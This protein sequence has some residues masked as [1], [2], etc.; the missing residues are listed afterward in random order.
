MIEDGTLRSRIVPALLG[1]VFDTEQSA[2]AFA[3]ATAKQRIDEQS[4][5]LDERTPTVSIVIPTFNRSGLLV[6]ALESVLGQT[7]KDYE[8]IV[9]DDGS[10]DDTVERLA[11]YMDRIRY[12]YQLNRGVSAALNKGIGV[13]RGKW[14]SVLASDDVWLPTKLENQLKALAEL[15]SEFG[16][17]FTDCSYSGDP[18][19]GLSAFEQAGLA[20]PLGP[21]P[22]N[23]PMK[24]V[25]AEHLVI[26]VQSL[27]V[28]SSLLRELNGF[29]EA[30]M[31][32]EDTDLLFRLTFKTRFCFVSAPLVRIDRTP[33][34]QRLTDLYADTSDRS[35]ACQEYKYR[36]W[37]DLRQFEDPVS[38]TSVRGSLRSVYYDWIIAKLYALKLPDAL[39]KIRSLR[40]MDHSYRTIILTLSFR[41]GRKLYTTLNAFWWKRATEN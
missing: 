36:K 10:T 22:L 11:P 30:M 31:V 6:N 38:R 39:Q 3:V 23:D 21:T 7:F 29:D 28:L 26:W 19:S 41:A 33:S 8:I 5:T 17:C 16:A 27:L 25:L 4:T 35:F 13:A 9:I 32:G 1:P 34:R 14:L 15:G 37:L 40:E 18:H 12:Y 24:W 2:D 20:S